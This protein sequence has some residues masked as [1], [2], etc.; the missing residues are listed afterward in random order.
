MSVDIN[1]HISKTAPIK[2]AGEYYGSDYPGEDF[3]MLRMETGDGVVKL[4]THSI[5]DIE[6]IVFHATAL[7]RQLR[8]EQG[9][10]SIEIPADEELSNKDW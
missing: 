3:A 6:A 2:V 9:W 5:A 1:I 8:D 10:D 7:A 4:Y